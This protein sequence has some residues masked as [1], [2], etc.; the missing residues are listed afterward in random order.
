MDSPKA[1][2][3]LS[4]SAKLFRVRVSFTKADADAN[5][6]PPPE[7]LQNAE[8][9]LNTAKQNGEIKYIRTYG[10]R[11][12]T[13]W[14]KVR[15]GPTFATSTTVFSVSV[16]AGAPDLPGV[17]LHPPTDADHLFLLSLPN[18]PEIVK[19]WRLEWLKIVIANKAREL[20]LPGYACQAQVYGALYAAQHGRAISKLPI[21]STATPDTKPDDAQHPY[22]LLLNRLREEITLHAYDLVYFLNPENVQRLIQE[23]KDAAE[24]ASTLETRIKP[25]DQEVIANLNAALAGPE[26]LGLDLPFVQLAAASGSPKVG[27]RKKA[28]VQAKRGIYPTSPDYG[29]QIEWDDTAMTAKFAFFD[30]KVYK[31]AKQPIDKTW[32]SEILR[33]AGIDENAMIEDFAEFDKKVKAK[34]SLKGVVVAKGQA[35][36]PGIGPYLHLC[37]KDSDSNADNSTL[38]MRAQQQRNIVVKDQLVAEVRYKTAPMIGR[39]IFGQESV[40]PRGEGLAVGAGNGVVESGDQFYA[41]FAGLPEV[42]E[43]SPITIR[44]SKSLVHNGDVNLSSG[45]IIFAGNV[46]VKGNVETG[47]LLHVGGDLKIDGSVMGGTIYCGGSIM[48]TGGITSSGEASIVAKGNIQ[49]DFVQNSRLRTGGDLNV[50][51]GLVASRIMANGAINIT[52]S[53]GMIIGGHIICGGSLNSPRVG[54]SDGAVTILEVGSNPG[55]VMR[56]RRHKARLERVTAVQDQDRQA[57]TTLEKRKANQ[58]TTHHVHQKKDL[59][60]RLTKADRIISKLKKLIIAAAGSGGKYNAGS[61]LMVSGNLADNCQITIGG[62]AMPAEERNG[63]NLGASDL[64][65]KAAS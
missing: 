62:V 5:E 30:P 20:N 59:R 64:V 54:R 32:L 13:L 35:S 15:E 51:R 1:K 41:R 24:K 38:D 25:L 7:L 53:D 46:E 44:L 21:R 6:K 34:L 52:N 58:L 43:G 18:K 49:V 4:Y 31:D 37:Y 10:E 17:E 61:K 28:A 47:A 36:V 39:D 2:P 48:I 42:I 50:A 29:W 26:V 40:P 60:L 3:T 14:S 27:V 8:A 33:A 57:L 56:E 16:A 63:V 23:I 22:K 12:E 55:P 19:P 9:R 45:N 65:P 11:L